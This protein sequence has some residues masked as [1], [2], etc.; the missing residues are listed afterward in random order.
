LYRTHARDVHRFALFLSGDPALAD[1]IVSE[2]FIRMWKVRSR[3]DL[4]T[5]KAYLFAIARNL[6]LQHRRDAARN[7]TLDEHMADT[8]PGPHERADARGQL[9]SVLA[10]LQS[11][12][13]IDRAALLMRTDAA[14]PYEDIARALGLSVSAAKVKVHRS[15]MKLSAVRRPPPPNTK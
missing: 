3:V 7:A 6:F 15:R 14:V 13:E 5:V 8:R 2:T 4:T 10:A 9:R 12:P 1:D 11:L